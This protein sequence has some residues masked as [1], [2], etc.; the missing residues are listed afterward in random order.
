MIIKFWYLLYSQNKWPQSQFQFPW[1]MLS[2]LFHATFFESTSPALRVQGVEGTPPGPSRPSRNPCVEYTTNAQPHKLPSAR[3]FCMFTVKKRFSPKHFALSNKI[4]IRYL[5]SGLK[6]NCH[7]RNSLRRLY[8]LFQ[9]FW[10]EL[11]FFAEASVVG[12]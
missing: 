11:Y 3:N 2:F 8:S 7:D 12:P 4:L 1:K 9:I 5:V 10:H 6:K